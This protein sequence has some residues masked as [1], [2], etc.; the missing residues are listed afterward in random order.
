MFVAVLGLLLV[1]L[2]VIVVI[3]TIVINKFRGKGC[4]CELCVFLCLYTL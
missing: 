1:L 2:Q 3:V 4:L